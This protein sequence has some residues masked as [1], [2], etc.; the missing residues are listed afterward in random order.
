[1]AQPPR[2][3]IKGR[4]SDV[5]VAGS[6]GVPLDI[7]TRVLQAAHNSG[8]ALRQ[9]ETGIEHFSQGVDISNPTLDLISAIKRNT[10]IEVSL[11][12]IRLGFFCRV[13]NLVAGVPQRIIE[14]SK[15][16]RGYIVINPA[17]ISGFSSTITFFPSAARAPGTYN[18]TN[19]NVSGVNTARI[20]LDVTVNGTPLTLVVNAQTQDPLSTNWATS[21]ADIFGGAAAVG[22]YY[23]S[24][25]ELGVDR[26]L[27]MQA[28]VG[29]G[30]GTVTFSVSGILKGG[31]A[32]PT[33]STIY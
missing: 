33:G 2:R 3:F 23:A 22:T 4:T 18:S 15:K 32:T 31:A 29:A 19:F 16:G 13:F 9:Q 6:K 28:V 17:E 26:Q 10:D 30:A 12:L 11:R 8:I 21:Q 14:P 5:I 27:R 7:N 20:F 1:M 25:G 24:L